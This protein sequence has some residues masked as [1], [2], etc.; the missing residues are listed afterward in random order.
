MVPEML[1]R[2]DATGVSV[3][4]VEFFLLDDAVDLDS[5]RAPLEVG[6]QLG[7]GSSRRSSRHR[8]GTSD[9]EPRG[10]C[11]LAAE[12]GMDVTLESPAVTPGCRP[13]LERPCGF[14]HRSKAERPTHHRLPAPRPHGRDGGAGLAE[15]PA[16]WLSYAQMC[17]G[18]DLAVRDDYVAEIFDRMVPGEGV[19]PIVEIMEALPAATLIDVEVP[20]ASLQ[21]AGVG[22]AERA[23]RIVSAARDLLGQVHP[24]R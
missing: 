10:L 7:A 9:G 23:R 1:A 12:Y 14:M 8:A 21:A 20:S 22:G 2:M 6:A 24:T 17:D 5:F 13:T 4:D 3:A 19:F 15:L 11:D 18:P 16:E